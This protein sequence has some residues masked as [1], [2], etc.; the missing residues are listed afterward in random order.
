MQY[1]D[2]T[3]VIGVIRGA[4]DEQIAGAV[5]AAMAG[6]LRTLEITLSREDA[7]DQ[8]ATTKA[9]FGDEIDL[10]AGTVLDGE[11]AYQAVS[12]GAQFIVTPML[13]MDVVEFCHDR[14]VPV[15][16]GAMTPT[17]VHAAHAA[18]ADLV[19]V[20]PAGSLGPGYVKS[21]KGPFPEI[22]LLPT[23]G[24]TVENAA[25]FFKAGAAGIG[26]GSELFRKDW[27]AA[28]DWDSVT[29]TA[30]AYV[31]AASGAR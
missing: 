28:G 3:P 31:D 17:E 2:E 22:P 16:L 5:A 14:D 11:Q 7:F 13:V 26:V 23:G 19:K 12:V 18:G 4:D 25:D 20:F 27:L 30:K 10:G 21:L 8:I 15:I 29:A 9:R 24:V 1:F 6:G